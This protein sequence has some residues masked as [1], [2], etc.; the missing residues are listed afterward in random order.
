[1]VTGTHALLGHGP[2]G[3]HGGGKGSLKGMKA[4]KIKGTYDR[5]SNR[6]V[7]C[8]Y[9][10]RGLQDS[11]VSPSV[12]E[13]RCFCNLPRLCSILWAPSRANWGR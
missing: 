10:T 11:V 3:G 5:H 7:D 13:R 2:P 4:K 8:A 9:T 12:T 1:M 6:D